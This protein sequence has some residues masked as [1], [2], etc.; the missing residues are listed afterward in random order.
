MTFKEFLNEGVKIGQ[1]VTV[2]KVTR[3]QPG[4]KNH[5]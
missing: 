5:K 3:P 4:K 1:E 2:I